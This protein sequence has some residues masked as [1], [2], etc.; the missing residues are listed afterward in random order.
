M[1]IQI[2]LLF[3]SVQYM[4]IYVQNNCNKLFNKELKLTQSVDDDTD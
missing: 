3:L 1:T 4:H 2:L